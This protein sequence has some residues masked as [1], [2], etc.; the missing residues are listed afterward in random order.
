MD[1][2]EPTWRIKCLCRRLKAYSY[3][4]GL[5]RRKNDLCNQGI[6]YTIIK[7]IMRR[8]IVMQK[9]KVLCKI[10]QYYVKKNVLLDLL[11][12]E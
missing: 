11:I 3:L 5:I 8:Y 10:K 12:Y 4:S 9:P 6:P 1:N 2:K 7:C